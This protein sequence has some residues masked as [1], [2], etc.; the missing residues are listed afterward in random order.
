A[1]AVLGN[2]NTKT[3]ITA[4]VDSA[5]G[6]ID[7]GHAGLLDA[8]KLLIGF[9]FIHPVIYMR[10]NHDFKALQLAAAARLKDETREANPAK[11]LKRILSSAWFHPKQ[12]ALHVLRNFSPKFSK[13]VESIMTAAGEAEKRPHTATLHADIPGQTRWQGLT[14]YL[15]DSQRD[16][17]SEWDSIEYAKSSM[18]ADCSSVGMKFYWDIPGPVPSQPPEAVSNERLIHNDINGS[19]PPEYGLDLILRGGTVNYGP[20]ADRQRANLQTVFFP[21]SYTDSLPA[22]RLAPGAMRVSTIFKLFLNVEDD[23]ILRIPL[24]E[25]SKDWKWKERAGTVT[26]H[27]KREDEKHKFRGKGKKRTARGKNNDQGLPSPDVRPFAW[28]DIKVFPD[29]TVTYN[30]D[31]IAGRHG[32]KNRLDLDVR[33]TEISSSVNH[34]LL[35]R[36]GRLTMDCDLSNPLQWNALRMWSFN[37]SSNDLELFILRDHLFLLTD[38]VGDWGSGPPPDYYT[39]VPFQYLL[40]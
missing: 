19:L 27:G 13:S 1:A 25:P 36:A 29:S 5:S 20:W 12:S 2:E 9:E 22:A 17:H 33:R 10:P 31:M 30:M 3:V 28:L 37:I 14:R 35:W 40:H 16:E 15:D 18:I 7:A 26:E 39:F 6:E 4:K 8:Y 11:G 24:R 32:Y 38:L 21:A 23:L 34:G